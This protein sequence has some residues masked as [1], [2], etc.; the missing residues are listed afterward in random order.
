MT[1]RLLAAGAAALALGLLAPV[2]PAVAAPVL[3]LAPPSPAPA[4]E[5][6]ARL[7][8]GGTGPEA[9]LVDNGSLM[10]AHALNAPGAP[11][12]ALGR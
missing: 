10:P 6:G 2:A 4:S 12:W 3:L 1:L 11:A 7:R 9:G 8:W 5:I